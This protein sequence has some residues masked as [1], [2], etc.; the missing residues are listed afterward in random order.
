MLCINKLAKLKLS[1]L[2]AWLF[3]FQMRQHL[4][5]HHRAEYSGTGTQALGVSL[6]EQLGVARKDG[7]THNAAWVPASH[8]V[9]RVPASEL[10]YELPHCILYAIFAFRIVE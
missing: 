6:R 9:A 2:S 8:N 3:I 10:F 7:T 1:E 4:R 5:V